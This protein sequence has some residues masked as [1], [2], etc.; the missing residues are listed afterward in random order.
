MFLSQ[1]N[2]E[3]Q[4]GPAKG[5]KREEK[6]EKEEDEEEAFDGAG[7]EDEEGEKEEEEE[8]EGGE[9]DEETEELEEREVSCRSSDDVLGAREGGDEDSFP[10]GHVGRG[11]GMF[12][13]SPGW[14][15]SS[16]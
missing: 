8:D 3:S 11:L 13:E 1:E 5:E 4:P 7:A 10:S 6:K 16:W 2:G 9:D 12:A 15:S 14:R